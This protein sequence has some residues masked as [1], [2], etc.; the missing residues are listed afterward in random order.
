VPGLGLCLPER[1]SEGW[2]VRP[3]ANGHGSVA[4]V[5][6]VRADESVLEVTSEDG[7]WRTPLSPRHAAIL[8]HL[9]DAGRAGLS[10]AALSRTLYGDEEHQVTVRAEI[11]RLR[12]TV[13]GLVATRP[14]RIAAGVEFRSQDRSEGPDNG[15]S[16]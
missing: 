3:S 4:A 6:D 1:L 2:L 11:S 14:Y 9:H 7:S 12:R 16:P 13:G 15:A 8:R 10:A 5:L